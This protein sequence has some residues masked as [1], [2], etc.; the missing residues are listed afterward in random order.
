MLHALLEAPVPVCSEV[1]GVPV[2]LPPSRAS[3][4][5]RVRKVAKLGRG[6]SKGFQHITATRLKIQ[7]AALRTN[8][9]NAVLRVTATVQV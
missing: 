5:A 9:K 8:V 1:H 7:N 3:R 6:R 4:S 2:V